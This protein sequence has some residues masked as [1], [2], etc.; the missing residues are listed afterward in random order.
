MF[1]FNNRKLFESYIRILVNSILSESKQRLMSIGYPEVVASLLFEK[2]GKHAPLIA[3]WLKDREGYKFR[4]DDT[5]N[6]PKNWWILSARQLFGSGDQIDI[7]EVVELYDAAKTSQETYN[8]TRERLGY[9][10][11]E[12]KI[13]EDTFRWLKA[14]IAERLF[15]NIFF[16]DM[17]QF[18]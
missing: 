4:K 11:S 3:K 5:V 13:D 16:S 8:A 10:T 1:E 2:F 17:F 12:E 6:Y 14:E 9:G 18:E 15:R 7:T